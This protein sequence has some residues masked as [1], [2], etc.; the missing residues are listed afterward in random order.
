MKN[1]FTFVFRLGCQYVARALK[2]PTAN[3]PVV[4]AGEQHTVLCIRDV[5]DVQHN[6]LS[7]NH[8]LLL[9]NR[10]PP[11]AVLLHQG[12]LDGERFWQHYER[13]EVE[14][15]GLVIDEVHAVAALLEEGQ[16]IKFFDVQHLV[17]A[18]RE[19][20][21][22]VHCCSRVR[23][24]LF[25]VVLKLRY[26]SDDVVR[27]VLPADARGIPPA[28]DLLVELQQAA[29]ELELPVAEGLTRHAST[30]LSLLNR[31]VFAG[32]LLRRLGVPLREVPA[33]QHHELDQGERAAPAVELGAYRLDGV[34]IDELRE[35]AEQVAL[36]FEDVLEGGAGRVQLAQLLHALV[37]VPHLVVVLLQPASTHA[38]RL[39]RHPNFF[40]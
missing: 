19:L 35:V 11:V 33:Q 39:L 31:L 6:S 38:D 17:Q 37:F 14:L 2:L 8:Q 21:A 20:L 25:F 29:S 26:F 40:L 24:Y 28:I 16:P 12:R 3:Q 23:S 5:E 7:G 34:A 9:A 4:G 30:N 18:A 13:L 22:E 32:A 27:E 36:T 15:S 10:K 1:W